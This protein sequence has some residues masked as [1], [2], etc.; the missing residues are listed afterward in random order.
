MSKSKYKDSI[1]WPYTGIPT[2]IA[3]EELIKDWCHKNFIAFTRYLQTDV[4]L[5][6]GDMD[7]EIVE[8]ELTSIIYRFLRKV[9]N[10]SKM[11]HYVRAVIKDRRNRKGYR[12]DIE[13]HFR[14]SGLNRILVIEVKREDCTKESATVQLRNYVKNLQAAT[15]AKPENKTTHF[16][17]LLVGLNQSHS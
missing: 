1:G 10:G 16:F 2:Q 3:M 8:A 5:L 11:E 17:G 12:H 13:V 9:E 4:T 15:E 14:G 7:H 6:L